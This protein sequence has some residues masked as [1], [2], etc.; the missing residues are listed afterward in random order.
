M[1]Q[2]IFFIFFQIQ[3]AVNAVNSAAFFSG[4]SVRVWLLCTELYSGPTSS[5]D[6][7]LMTQFQAHKGNPESVLGTADIAILV[8]KLN[9]HYGMIESITDD[10]PTVAI[11]YD[12]GLNFYNRLIHPESYNSLEEMMLISSGRANRAKMEDV[13]ASKDNT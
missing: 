11:K 6:Q 12:D 3:A 8:T 13:E 2:L 9:Q 4:V 1:V 5:S 7:E 10:Y